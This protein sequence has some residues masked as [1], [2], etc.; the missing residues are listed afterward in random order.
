MCYE[1]KIDY[2]TRVLT[3]DECLAP[4]WENKLNE[5]KLN[6]QIKTMD[7]FN[8]DLFLAYARPYMKLIQ[9]DNLNLTRK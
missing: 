7:F 8:K 5:S 2:E 1:Y 9:A 3:F 4:N 6:Y